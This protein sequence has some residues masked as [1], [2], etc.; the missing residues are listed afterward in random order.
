MNDAGMSRRGLVIAGLF[1]LAGC[2][3][4]PSL[5]GP[6]AVETLSPQIRL[7]DGLPK[8]GWQL[9]V[10]T[11]T[12]P[13]QLAGS[14]IALSRR[15]FSIE[16]YDGVAWAE[17]LPDMHQEQIV[18]AFTRSGK[19]IGVGPDSAD[20]IPDFL[21]ETKL[22]LFQASFRPKSAAPDVNLRMT[23]RLFAMPARRA[24][25]VETLHESERAA[26]GRIEDVIAAFNDAAGRLLSKLVVFA[27][28]APQTAN[29]G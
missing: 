6:D 5:R 20:F 16:Y 3:N 15:P 17:D 10:A 21:L 19:I 28:T 14:G 8:V 26:S 24:V 25:G 29:A 22:S 9:A 11:P 4:L 2:L 23:A 7:P 1:G 27:L 13:A 12:T 18:A